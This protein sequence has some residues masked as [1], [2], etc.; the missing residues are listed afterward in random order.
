MSSKRLRAGPFVTGVVYYLDDVVS[1]RNGLAG[2]SRWTARDPLP[3]AADAS[4]RDRRDL[5]RILNK[6][7]Y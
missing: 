5:T 1:R 6:R 4:A 2:A 7:P 3:V